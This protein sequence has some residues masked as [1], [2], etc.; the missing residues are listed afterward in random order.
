MSKSEI[1]KVL[2]SKLEI[3]QREDFGLKTETDMKPNLDSTFLPYQVVQRA[4]DYWIHDSYET[5]QQF[6]LA[7]KGKPN[8]DEMDIFT[9]DEE[10]QLH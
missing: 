3:I 9:F 10:E 7:L 2:L 1:D 5:Y 4:N 6:K 8:P